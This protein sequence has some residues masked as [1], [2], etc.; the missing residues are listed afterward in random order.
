M[1]KHNEMG[2]N[3]EI[4]SVHP[5]TQ[6]IA[7]SKYGSPSSI[8]FADK[9][10][11]ISNL[12]NVSEH[13]F[14]EEI[15]DL[16]S[17]DSDNEEVDDEKILPNEDK[18]SIP[19]FA[20][21]DWREEKLKF[22]NFKTIGHD[23]KWL[24]NILLSDNS[25]SESDGE[26]TENEFQ[27]MLKMHVRKK[28]VQKS[29]LR[30]TE[31]CNEEYSN[32]ASSLLSEHDKYH[33][34]HKK[35]KKQKKNI[36]Q[37]HVK[38][39]INLTFSKSNIKKN[40]KKKNAAKLKLLEA[41]KLKLKLQQEKDM[42]YKRKKVWHIISKKEI[43]KMCRNKTNSRGT[44]LATLKKVAQGCQR[45]KRKEAARS[46]KI[47]KEV[48]P[49]AKRMAREMLLYWKKF[50]KVEKEHR[51]K[52]EKE[53]Q[54]QRK[55][56]EEMRE[57][58]RQQRKL[59]FLITQTELYAHF[60]SR[61][62]KGNQD[63]SAQQ[64]DILKKLDDDSNLSNRSVQG[65]IL[66]NHNADDYDPEE[67][68]NRALI[69]AQNAVLSQEQK[70]N[71]FD[72]GSTK[73]ASQTSFDSTF[74]LA[75]PTMN[76]KK[77]LP[78]PKIFE[79]KLK[80][81][82]L[83]G[84]NW[85]INLYEQGINGILA[86]E[87]GLGK[88]VQ[89]ISLLAY[90]AEAH[91]IWG[92]FVIVSPAST[93]HNWQQEFAKF[94]PQF[95]VL[96]YWGDPSD[97]KSLRKFWNQTSSYLTDSEKAPFHV[98]ITSYQLIVQDVKYFQRIKW[99]YLIL[100]EAHAIKSSTS[101]RW[102]ILLGYNCRNRLLLTGTPIQNTMAE[103]WA[104]LHFIM[105]MLFDNHEEFNEWFSKDIENHASE[106]KPNLDQNQLSRL[107]MILKPF[108]LRRV[109]KDVENELSEKI[110]IKVMCQMSSRQ[111]L[112]YQAVKNKIMFEDLLQSTTSNSEKSTS[113]LM[114]L[115]MQFRKVM[116]LSSDATI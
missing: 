88:T 104:L 61:K 37:T 90:L 81:Y 83:K 16:S 24:M 30:N 1:E 62:M 108:M 92:P 103:L 85:L 63:S 73:A 33:E 67:M 52:A 93:L 89:S 106:K 105:P 13:L 75:N 55:Q 21:K 116:N 31:Q 102:K 99:Q 50:D 57:M 86:D 76:S 80:T 68:K 25:E 84:M 36:K 34:K 112:F 35:R 74:S 26:I 6:P 114:N 45:E 12:I 98:L 96:P 46:Q 29:F 10:L 100:D 111:K 70:I 22:Y 64:T 38:K 87:M 82:Q 71:G 27:E 48:F 58:K 59:N 19:I 8:A 9:S 44:S 60:M 40:L 14:Q 101:L 79:G 113:L 97:R 66:V 15:S 94:L 56:D 5:S 78:Q 109:K 53:A 95:K 91:D 18:R 47:S 42:T 72:S 28:A 107:H 77:Q 41:K 39:P 49:R 23:R 11:D 7:L 115:V 4:S 65:G 69:N 43:P 17:L 20:K 51:K 32:F 2:I 54:E 3:Q 110:E